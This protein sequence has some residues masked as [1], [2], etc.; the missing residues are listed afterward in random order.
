[1][2]Q[3][4]KKV[5]ERKLKKLKKTDMLKSIGYSAESPWSQS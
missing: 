3:K 2:E 4:T 5:E 1:M